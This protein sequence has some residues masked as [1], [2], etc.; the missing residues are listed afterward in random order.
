MNKKIIIGLML[1]LVMAIALTACVSALNATD[2]FNMKSIKVSPD[3]DIMPGEE[4]T[5]TVKVAN[6]DNKIDLDVDLTVEILDAS[7]NTAED[8]NGDSLEA[9][10]SFSLDNDEDYTDLS[11][12]DYTF[13]FNMPYDAEDG[14]T[15]IVTVMAEYSNQDNS[16]DI[17][18]FYENQT[19]DMARESKDL[20]LLKYGV[21][22]D[23]ISCD[24]N[25]VL[26]IDAINM[27]RDD[28]KNVVF[29]AVNSALAINIKDTIA[30]VNQYFEDDDDV[31]KSYD[32]AIAESVKPGKYPIALKIENK[33]AKGTST[34]TATLTVAKCEAVAE[35]TTP[36]ITP[37]TPVVIATPVIPAQQT[38]QPT[39]VTTSESIFEKYSLIWIVLAY[40]VVLGVGIPLLIKF[41]RAKSE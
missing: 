27:G 29:T 39:I 1:V 10:S 16:S 26:D 5:V 12:D 32:I 9:D 3:N 35:E 20:Q 38:I 13:I 22:P 8:I 2:A 34:Y 31:K 24:R 28:E 33:D 40:V 17:G 19:I 6:T 37:T 7:G 23:T 4:V 36:V 11:E 18:V 14:D 15:F 30:K 41:L 21:T 25:V